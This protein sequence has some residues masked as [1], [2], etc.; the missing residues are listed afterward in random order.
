MPEFLLDSEIQLPISDLPNTKNQE[1]FDALKPIHQSLTLLAGMIDGRVLQQGLNAATSPLATLRSSGL[2][3]FTCPAAVPILQG[4][5]VYF[6]SN[7]GVLNAYVANSTAAQFLAMGYCSQPGGVA[8]GAY[9]EFTPFMGV[10][11]LVSGL[12]TGNPYYLNNSGGISLTPGTLYQRVGVAL[13]PNALLFNSS[14]INEGEMRY[15]AIGL[16]TTTA[17][18]SIT[19]VYA[20][21]YQKIGGWVQGNAYFNFRNTSGAVITGF[22]IVGL[23]FVCNNTNYGWADMYYAYLGTKYFAYVQAGTNYILAGYAGGIPLGDYGVMVAFS[24]PTA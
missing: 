17:G 6:A 21:A 9:G 18:L 10:N 20:S 4:Q 15:G 22:D 23:P 5:L 3:R 24:Y 8:A 11:T 12:S 19:S 1:L 16:S 7:V 2:N 14:M 13:S